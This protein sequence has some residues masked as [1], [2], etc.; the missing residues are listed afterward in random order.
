MKVY[1]NMVNNIAE[2]AKARIHSYKTETVYIYI[3][4]LRFE[5]YRYQS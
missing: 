4:I 5:S 3:V 2:D 1:M